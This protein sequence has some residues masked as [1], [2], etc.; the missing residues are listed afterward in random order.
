MSYRYQQEVVCFLN[1][2]IAKS[3]SELHNYQHTSRKSKKKR[4]LHNF[5]NFNVLPFHVLFTIAEIEMHLIYFFHIRIVYKGENNDGTK[6]VYLHFLY[7][8]ESSYMHLISLL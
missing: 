7:L 8:S 6:D 4:L 5:S 1:F 2:Y 3:G